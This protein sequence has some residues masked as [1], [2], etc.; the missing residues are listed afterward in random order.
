MNQYTALKTAA[1][2]DLAG[3]PTTVLIA[4]LVKESL[5]FLSACSLTE[6]E[7]EVAG[8]QYFS[9]SK[10]SKISRPVL[11][12]LWSSELMPFDKFISGSYRDLSAAKID[13]LLYT[14]AMSFCC[15]N[16]LQKQGDKKTPATFFECFIGNIFARELGVSP[17]QRVDV[18]NLDMKA[19]LPTDYLF[20]LGAE[21]CRIHLP[22]KL[23]T[24]ERVVQ[25]WAHQ[26][27]LDGVYGV[28]RFRGIL[29]VGAETKLDARTLK[30]TEICLPDQWKVYQMFI[31]QLKRVYYLDVP[32]RYLIMSKAYPY[33][34]VKPLSAFFHEKAKLISPTAE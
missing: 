3:D 22:I 29:V 32:R 25:I 17:R 31:S 30:V 6:L 21:K 24:R 23:S 33:I 10:G 26:R 2:K 11:K 19:T 13:K 15:A 34:Q 7:S 14:M 8:K 5:K 9:F 1:K 28:G 27:V 4:E 16:D 20:D 18:L 12:S